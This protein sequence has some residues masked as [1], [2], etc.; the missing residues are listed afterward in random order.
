MAMSRSRHGPARISRT[1]GFTFVELAAALFILAVGLSA[2]I[3]LVL[4]AVGTN[5]QN[6]QDSSATTMARMV[7]QQFLS[8]SADESWPAAS[9][10]WPP[11]LAIT[12]CA[13]NSHTIDTT[14]SASPGS[15]ATLL[16]GGGVDFS[17][18]LGGAGAPSNYYMLY[19]DCATTGTTVY[20][21]RWHVTTLS[22][23]ANLVTVSAKPS[24]TASTGGRYIAL[25]VTIC[26]IAG[27]KP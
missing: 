22:P 3:G 7:M 16:S 8:V 12:D 1:A 2:C 20:D 10:S 27:R 5:G 11:K 6:R 15:G 21:I 19:Q 26:T 18:T 9:G 13:G 25:P 24:L 14:G 17:K 4:M 23:Y